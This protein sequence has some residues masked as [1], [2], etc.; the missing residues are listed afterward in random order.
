MSPRPHRKCAESKTACEK[1]FID[2]LGRWKRLDRSWDTTHNPTRRMKCLVGYRDSIKE[3]KLWDGIDRIEVILHLN[4]VLTASGIDPIIEG[5]S[6]S[7]REQAN[8]RSKKE[9]TLKSCTKEVEDDCTG[10]CKL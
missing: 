1:Q 3:R 2:R 8:G 5:F 9:K 6:M 10:L 7:G 4:D